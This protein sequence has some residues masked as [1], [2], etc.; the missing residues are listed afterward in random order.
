MPGTR[1]TKQINLNQSDA[2]LIVDA[3]LRSTSGYRVKNDSINRSI[4][5]II[6]IIIIAVVSRPLSA[7]VA[8]AATSEAVAAAVAGAAAVR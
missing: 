4:I 8:A 5:I 2:E 1:H 6:I 7:A 3:S